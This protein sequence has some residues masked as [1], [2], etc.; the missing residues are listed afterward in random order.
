MRYMLEQLKELKKKQGI[1][2]KE[3][4]KARAKAAKICTEK[5]QAQDA[6]DEW[7]HKEEVQNVVDHWSSKK[8]IKTR[9]PMGENVSPTDAG[10]P[11]SME[12]E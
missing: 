8:H 6:V 12:M 5:A 4:A 7:Q 3:K 11:R 1:R 9:N 2:E 10:S